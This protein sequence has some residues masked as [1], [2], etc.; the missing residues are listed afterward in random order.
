MNDGR[1]ARIRELSAAGLT[2]LQIGREVGL[3]AE[4]VRVLRKADPLT[5]EQR[6]T[7][8]IVEIA[9]LRRAL[10]DIDEE[11]EAA[12]VDRILGLD[13]TSPVLGSAP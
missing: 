11:I 1:Q 8:L 9:R 7:R 5:L 13:A 6:R 4:R 2:N 10:R 3:S 12:S